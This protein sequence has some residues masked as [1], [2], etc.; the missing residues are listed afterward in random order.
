MISWSSLQHLPTTRIHCTP[1]HHFWTYSRPRNHTKSTVCFKSS[2]AKTH[3]K[4]QLYRIH[5]ITQKRL[6]TPC[7]RPLL[8][9]QQNK[10]PHRISLCVSRTP[11]L[12]LSTRYNLYITE[13]PTQVTHNKI[14]FNTVKELSQF[15]QY[16][17]IFTT[18]YKS[19]KEIV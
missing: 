14:T 7:S 19:N 18:D 1:Q 11:L 17:H 16:K 13:L 9:P 8:N 10:K 6:T 5:C 4:S 12:I 2:L 3:N 15:K